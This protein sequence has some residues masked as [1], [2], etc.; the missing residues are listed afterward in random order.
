M[1][2]LVQ[3]AQYER[4]R[5]PSRGGLESAGST[6]EVTVGG[7]GF[8]DR[9]AK[10]IPGE[11]IAGYMAI[12][13]SLVPSAAAFQETREKLR[14]TKTVSE[15]VAAASPTAPAMSPQFQLLLHDNMPVIVLIMCLILT[16]LYIRQVAIKSGP[17]TPWATHA[18][19][20][21]LAFFVWAYAIQGSA[22]TLSPIGNLYYGGLAAALVAFFTL[23]SGLFSPAPQSGTVAAMSSG[24]PGRTL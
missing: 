20:A 24:A 5:V 17:G 23:V 6:V 11:V 10:Y 2:R 8:A 9:I 16:P 4:V 21:T 12:D 18:V 13:R 1:G 3:P 22:F 14:G 19:V 7:D 15:G